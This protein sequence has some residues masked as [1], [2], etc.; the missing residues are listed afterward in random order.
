MWHFELESY[1]PFYMILLTM[2]Y[3]VSR[4]HLIIIPHFRTQIW[5][6][7]LKSNPSNL[8]FTRSTTPSSR[9]SIDPTW[10]RVFKHFIDQVVIVV[11][12]LSEPNSSDELRLVN[13]NGSSLLLH[14]TW[15]SSGP[16]FRRL[17]STTQIWVAFSPSVTNS[18]SFLLSRQ[19][20]N[21]HTKLPHMESFELPLLF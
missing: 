16:S 12:H 9:F 13:L 2:T 6:S 20:S 15:E 4:H 3:T 5:V 10:M 7:S 21:E 1:L 14:P 19:T 17:P 8:L 11:T 18:S